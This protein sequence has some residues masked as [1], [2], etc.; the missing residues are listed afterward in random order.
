MNKLHFLWSIPALF[1]ASVIVGAL[2]SNTIHYQ[3]KYVTSVTTEVPDTQKY[4]TALYVIHYND[5][6]QGATS[7]IDNSGPSGVDRGSACKTVF[8]WG[9]PY[10]GTNRNIVDQSS[11]KG[12]K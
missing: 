11:V 8:N 1:L 2:G 7:D 6:T 5:G 10:S 9:F 12:D 4:A 3:C